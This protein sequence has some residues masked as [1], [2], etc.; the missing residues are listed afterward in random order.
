[1]VDEM[2]LEVLFPK[3]LR[4]GD[5][6]IIQPA[7]LS[8][9]GRVR[10]LKVTI[11]EAS[12]LAPNS[13][14]VFSQSGAKIGFTFKPLFLGPPYRDCYWIEATTPDSPAEDSPAAG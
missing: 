3:E 9:P 10:L 7:T 8:E 11:G 14:P 5:I 6:E 2:F 13:L 4:E 12:P 1:M